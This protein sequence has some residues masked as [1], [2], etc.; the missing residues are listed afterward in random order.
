MKRLILFFGICLSSIQFFAQD[1][2]LILFSENGETF[3]AS[4]NGALQNE[5]P[6]SRV[7]C[8]ALT[9]EFYQ[10]KIDF[11]DATLLDFNA[12]MALEK[13]METT[14]IIKQNKKG[15]YVL[16]LFGTSTLSDVSVEPVAEYVP[17]PPQTKETVIEKPV[18]ET[19]TVTTT[20]REVTSG[21]TKEGIDLEMSVPGMEVKVKM[22]VPELTMES[23]STYTET[24]TTTTTTS[25]RMTRPVE[26]EVEVI[27]QPNP[28][29]GY[30]GPIGCDWPADDTDI[31]TAVKSVKSKTFEDSKMTLAKQIAK[32]KCLTAAQV[33]QL[34]MTFDYEESKLEFAKYAYDYTFDQGNYYVVNDAFDFEL[35]IDELNEYLESR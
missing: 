29:P 22:E 16:R 2:A 4:L 18:E 33:K 35:T 13:G 19:S 30:N 17:L 6:A 25:E 5:T 1:A 24:T 21:S 12:N 26:E 14:A 3:T 9:Q 7:R 15:K 31:D 28:M 20:T 34:M 8:E 32:S 27:E 11:E 23:G 10:V